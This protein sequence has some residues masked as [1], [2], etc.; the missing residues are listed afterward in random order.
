LSFRERRAAPKNLFQIILVRKFL[1]SSN[2]GYLQDWDFSAFV[3]KIVYV[4]ERFLLVEKHSK[5]SCATFVQQ[6]IKTTQNTE[7]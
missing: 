3:V 6:L 1:Q 5:K 7:Y 2:R 4:V